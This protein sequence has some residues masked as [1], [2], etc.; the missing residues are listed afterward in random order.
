MTESDLLKIIGESNAALKGKLDVSRLATSINDLLENIKTLSDR[1]EALRLRLKNLKSKRDSIAKITE[2]TPQA[3]K[4]PAQTR[5]M[6]AFLN[7]P[8]SFK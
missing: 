2:K 5:V 8:I 6:P 7:S 4:S 1:R 3:R